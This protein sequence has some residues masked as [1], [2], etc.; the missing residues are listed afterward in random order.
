MLKDEISDTSSKMQTL[1]RELISSL[2]DTEKFVRVFQY[3]E[4]ARNCMLAGI[5]EQ[6]P[7]CSEE[8]L[9][10]RFAVRTIS[11]EFTI[12]E[13]NWDPEVEGY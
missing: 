1:Q 5:R 8:E 4:F 7:S 12:K 10:K 13:F 3:M 2:S 11:K 6:Y 9:W